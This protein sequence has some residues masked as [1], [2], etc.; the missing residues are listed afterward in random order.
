MTTMDAA[1]A[2]RWH[3]R[4]A[5]A[6]LM[7]LAGLAL[8]AARPSASL[9]R[10]ATAPLRPRRRRSRHRRR[11]HSR[12]SPRWRWRRSS[13]RRMRSP[14]RS[15]RSSRA[16]SRS[17]ASSVTASKD[18]RADYT[19][20][21]Y[22]VAAKDKTATKVSYIWDVTDPTGK[23]VN[24]ITGEEVVS[25]NAGKDPWAALTPQVAQSIAG[26]AASSFVAWLPSQSTQAANVAQPSSVGAQPVGA[27]APPGGGSQARHRRQATPGAT[28][29]PASAAEPDHGQHRPRWPGDGD[30]ALGHRR[31]RRRQHLADGRHPARADEQGR[32]GRRE[33]DD[34][35]PTG[36]K[37]RSR[38][39]RPKQGK[40]PIHIEWLVR[41]PQ[42]KKLGTVSQRNEIPEGSLDGEWGQT[43]DA[44]RRRRRPGHRQAAAAAEGHQLAVAESVAMARRL[45]HREAAG[46]AVSAGPL[47][48]ARLQ[49]AGALARRRPDVNGVPSMPFDTRDANR[50]REAPRIKLVAGNS[51]RPLAEAICRHPQDAPRQERGPALRGHGSVRRGA[52]EHARRGRL[53]PAVDLVP[54]QRQPDGAAD[55]GRR[56]EAVDGA[57]H[58]G[59]HA[60]L[61]LRPAGS[62]ARARARPSRP[63]SS[64]T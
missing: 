1:A 63:S 37:A 43:A 22:I 24:R 20:R 52:G 33:A 8:P 28:D 41:D 44:G 53:R 39:A 16:R 29:S 36:S 46:H 12:R 59:R 35:W 5:L 3:P 56:A 57:A 31:A 21:G 27:A 40:Q 14:S 49:G 23:R 38:S 50:K 54:R 25:G 7:A 10:L 58:H 51:N 64:P 32:L 26:K 45:P 4:M 60:L 48:A 17:S 18:E 13:A 30:R 62:P 15:S 2:R 19:L 61:R 42:G 55:P 34:Q 11:S 6:V 9:L 47:V